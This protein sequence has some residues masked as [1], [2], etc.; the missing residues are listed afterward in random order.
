MRM[1]SRSA[2]WVA[3]AVVFSAAV[4]ALT[5]RTSR[6]GRPEFCGPLPNTCDAL[7]H[8][9]V[10]FLGEVLGTSLRP[11]PQDGSVAEDAVNVVNFRMLRVFKGDATNAG[12][13]WS[14]EFHERALAHR[15][16][17]GQ[18]VVVYARRSHRR[19]LE[20]TCGRTREFNSEDAALSEELMQL[21][22]C[23]SAK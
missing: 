11:R 17:K 18:R 23:H 5:L 4:I 19:L 9:D 22:S 14:G 10:V 20:T 7:Q 8:A 21:A 3:G 6:L 12:Q 16:I 1:S 13:E 15:F 2:R